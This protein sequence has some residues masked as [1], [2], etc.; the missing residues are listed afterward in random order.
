MG[1]ALFLYCLGT[2]TKREQ[3]MSATTT[4]VESGTDNEQQQLAWVNQT[5]TT[6]LTGEFVDLIYSG[7]LSSRTAQN[8]TS[9]G[10]VMKNLRVD[11]GDLYRNQNKDGDALVIV[12]EDEGKRAT[13]YRVADDGD[14]VEGRGQPS[15]T[16]I[17]AGDQ[18]IL[19]D[20]AGQSFEVGE[21]SDDEVIVWYNG[22]SGQIIGRALDIHGR[23]FAEYKNDG[24]LVKGLL[25]VAEGWRNG[26]KGQ[27]VRDGLGPRVARAPVPRP[28]LVGNEVSI[29]I[30]RWN[31][32]RMYEATITDV[33]GEQVDMEYSSDFEEN[34]ESHEIGMHLHHGEGWQDKPANAQE[35]ARQFNI[36]VGG[37]TND[38]GFTAVQQNF[39]TSVTTAVIEAGQRNADDAFMNGVAGLMD[40]HGVEGDADEI[41]AEINARLEQHFEDDE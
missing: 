34:F 11:E 20:R 21:L 18:T 13:D 7:D 14:E 38:D 29:E 35:P 15:L 10:V 22:M 37:E 39:I 8:G 1:A 4:E 16:T 31:G 40:Q 23:P 32:G 36:T 12:D 27:M 5:P 6:K 30:G 19:T 41:R 3:N 33:D 9:F 17:Q 2:N 26:N 24:Y 28:D 25:Q